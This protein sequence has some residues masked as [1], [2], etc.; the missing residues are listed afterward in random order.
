LGTD[1]RLC[2]NPGLER[3]DDRLGPVLARTPAQH[4]DPDV[5]VIRYMAWGNLQ[6]LNAERDIIRLFNQKCARE[7]KKIRVELF[8]P[9]AGGYAQKLRLMLASGDAPDVMRLDHYEFPS[10]VPR[11]CLRD[12]TDYAQNDPELNVDDFHP[13]VMRENLYKGR[14]YGFNVMFGPLVCYYNKDLFAR[15]GLADPYDLWK[16]DVATGT[17]DR[18]TWARFEQDAQ[19]LTIRRGDRTTQWGFLFP[20]GQGPPPWCWSIWVYGERG[21][22]LSDD[23]TKCLLDSPQAVAGLTRMRDLRF[24]ARVAP[25]N[26]DTAASAFTFESG[27]VGMEFQ[28]SGLAPR[29][30]DNIR[31]FHW[32]IVPTP[33]SNG[34]PYG[35]IKG[36]QLCMWAG[37]R[38][39][40]AAWE[41]I[42]Y[43][44]SPQTELRLY[45]DTLRRNV[46][47]RRSSL[48]STEFLVAHA[49]PYHTDAFLFAL[50]HPRE[51]PIDATWPV[52]TLEMQ[53][54]MDMMFTDARCQPATILPEAAEAV[55]RAIATERQHMKRYLTAEA[56]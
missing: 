44:V 43:V 16:Q 21:Q 3:L 38:H 6:Q 54:Y 24:V 48:A 35:L 51:L 15:A 12:L 8:M 37:C 18:W 53:R 52:W 30:R 27:N 28:W 55:G 40:E 41:W 33:Y 1:A 34:H 26:A 9:P 36:N 29:Y 22:I 5:I 23:G 50:E 31:D 2:S 45:G 14:I 32:D 4:H 20:S 7:G 42:K 46:P 17:Y 13:A 19:A 39:P 56:P 47:T 49:E 10:I 11:G 25:S